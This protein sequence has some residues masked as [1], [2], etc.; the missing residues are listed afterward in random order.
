M[1][2]RT[3]GPGWAGPLAAIILL[4]VAASFLLQL[5]PVTAPLFA[6]RFGWSE[7][8]IGYLMAGTMAS[9]IL[10]LSA[11]SPLVRGLG[12]VR[13]VQVALLV[14]V[15]GAALLWLPLWIAPLGACLLIGLAYGPATPAGGEVLQRF[16]PQ[17][18]RSLVFSIKQAGVPAGGAAAGFLLPP[19]AESAGLEAAVGLAVALPLAV[20]ALAQ[21]FR[22]RTDAGRDRA[23]RWSPAQLLGL[24]NL[25]LPLR[26]LRGGRDLP[27]LAGVGCGLAFCQGTLNAFLVTYLVAGLGCALGTAGAVFAL[28]QAGGIVGRL[29]LG[30]LADRLGSAVAV[31]R[32]SAVASALVMLALAAAAPGWPV[33]ALSLLGFLAGASVAGWNGVHLGEVARRARPGQVGE[34]S[35]GAAMLAFAGL[36]AGPA[37]LAT[38][39]A[40]SGGFAAGLVALSAVPC[41]ALLASLLLLRARY[42]TGTA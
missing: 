25:T 7:S 38:I 42:P 21:R 8:A 36:I 35:A 2:D 17:R 34:A 37:L 40:A 19:V 39:L 15:L 10:C 22:A 23:I 33:W 26:A 27:A 1:R 6:A 4:Q 3:A 20:V 18:H 9:A 30:W 29:A 32:L 14:G 5:L 24:R 16:A 11:S 41:A 31:I 13:A 12:P 28:M